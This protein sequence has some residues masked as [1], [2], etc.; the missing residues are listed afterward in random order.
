MLIDLLVIAI[1]LWLM[2]VGFGLAV[3]IFV[4]VCVRPVVRV[5]RW[6]RG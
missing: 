2:L 5:V 3:N 6:M 4:I 1:V